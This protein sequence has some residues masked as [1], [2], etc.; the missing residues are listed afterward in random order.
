MEERS[1]VWVDRGALDLETKVGRELELRAQPEANAAIGHLVGAGYRVVLLGPDAPGCGPVETYAGIELVDVLPE[2]AGGWLV[3]SDEAR[4]GE[5][6]GHPRLRTILVGPSVPDRG[7]AHRPSDRAA[8][9]LV[10]AALVVLAADAM[11]EPA[12]TGAG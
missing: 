10:D 8:R 2:D 12:L 4:C 7:L 9:D 1:V 11:P 6:R 5:A 3:T